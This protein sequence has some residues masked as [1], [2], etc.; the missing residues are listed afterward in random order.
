MFFIDTTS[1]FLDQ[2]HAEFKLNPQDGD[3]SSIAIDEVISGIFYH[4]SDFPQSLFYSNRLFDC[5]RH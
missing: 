3:R 2:L 1:T 5:Y 4:Q